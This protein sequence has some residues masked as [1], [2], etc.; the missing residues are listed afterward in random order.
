MENTWGRR[1]ETTRQRDM[2]RLKRKRQVMHGKISN[3][4]SDSAKETD[5]KWDEGSNQEEEETTRGN[6]QRQIKTKG[7]EHR[8]LVHS[9]PTTRKTT[10]ENKKINKEK[11]IERRNTLCASIE[12][13]RSDG[14]EEIMIQ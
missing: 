5:V 3:D 1:C 8:Y 14:D 10:H 6:Q 7:K 9:A 11:R 4:D 13:W 12:S 2:A